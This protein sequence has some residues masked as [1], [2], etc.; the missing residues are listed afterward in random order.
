MGIDIDKTTFNDQDYAR[1]QTALQHNL[2]SLKDILERQ[3]FDQGEKLLGAE[4][5]LYIID[6]EGNCAAL[7]Q[8]LLKDANDKLVT[9]ELNQYNLEYNLKPYALDEQ[10]FLSAEKD[11]VHRIQQLNTLA[12]KYEAQ[13]LPIGILP[14]LKTQDLDPSLITPRK[15][16]QALIAQLCKLRGND[17]RVNI[18]G[19]TQLELNRSDIV[20]EGVN[21]SLQIHHRAYKDEFVDMYNTIQLIT[22]VVL[23]ISANSPFLLG[24]QLWDETRIPLFKQS[25][26]TRPRDT[27]SWHP[28]ARVSFGQGWL[29]H[30]PMDIFEEA[31]RL[32]PPI[33]PIC[34]IQPSESKLDE[35]RLHLGTIWLWNRPIYDPEN[36]G[37]LR[38]EMR[39]LPAGPTPID[40][41]ANGA[42]YIGLAEYLKHHI[43]ELLPAIPFH[44]A[45]HNFYRSAQFS[46][47]ANIV[48][49]DKHQMGSKERPITE[50]I[51]SCIDL[52]KKGLSALGI[53]QEEINRYMGVI[54]ARVAR[55]INGALW[56]KQ[57]V[58]QMENRY[59]RQTALTNMLM[60]YIQLSNANKPIHEW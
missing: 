51:D 22:P 53:G 55:R 13:V 60:N 46:L 6:K 25:I 15:R 37:H 23:A 49:P 43:N 39:A 59:G 16:Y 56:Q 3:S 31:V 57:Q 17:F 11:L 35:L 30:S 44:I 19:E 4:L 40:M 18:S 36:N 2:T 7:N 27:F 8:A 48:W 10:A 45:E 34:A 24:H 21:T 41:I 5:E 32:F 14:T 29:R 26:D 58:K 52:A 47:N 28:S 12:N 50:V 42:F 1:F 33:L 54:Q 9:P 38:I 20:L